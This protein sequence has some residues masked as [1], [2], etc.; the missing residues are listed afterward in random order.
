M[1]DFIDALVS[2]NLGIQVG[3]GLSGPEVQP[4]PTTHFE[5]GAATQDPE[6][7]RETGVPSQVATT[8]AEHPGPDS[9][10]ITPEKAAASDSVPRD[11]DPAPRVAPAPIARAPDVSVGPRPQPR[12]A[13]TPPPSVRPIPPTPV[14]VQAAPTPD[15]RADPVPPP[16]SPRQPRQ[17]PAAPAPR[18]R[19]LKPAAP[20]AAPLVT[21]APNRPSDP[22]LERIIRQMVLS[23]RP[24]P[25]ASPQPT[26]REPP[27][28][29]PQAQRPGRP[30]QGDAAP[31]LRP[32]ETPV[33][34]ARD[35]DLPRPAPLQPLLSRSEI[36]PR[37]T[38]P[39]ASLA[40]LTAPIPAAPIA[41]PEMVINVR[42]GRIEV[43]GTRDDAQAEPAKATPRPKPV[44][45][46][47]DEYLENRS[48]EG[49]R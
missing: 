3:P 39:D 42:I 10:A 12:D 16:P 43:K 24:D 44:I 37:R 19:D 13:G 6:G 20:A 47:L 17:E 9:R 40:P 31:P 46:S 26:P 49:E 27:A 34:A 25:L 18:P 5:P 32:A 38:A 4:R 22:P 41:P 48:R 35:P 7:T 23:P 2:R 33:Q 36:L 8:H 14:P 28:A 29:T 15:L 45:M 1:S 21:K 30:L 11:D